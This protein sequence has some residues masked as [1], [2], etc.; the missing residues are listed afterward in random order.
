M[1]THEFSLSETVGLFYIETLLKANFPCE[2]CHENEIDILE[3]EAENHP[4]LI[5][6]FPLLQD[7]SSAS[8]PLKV[9]E[10]ICFFGQ[11][12]E[13]FVF[14]HRPKSNHVACILKRQG[15]LIYVDN[16]LAVPV[17]KNRADLASVICYAE[18]KSLL[19]YKKKK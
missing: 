11:T 10:E 13:K 7:D 12:Y 3:Y 5:A 8:F 15:Q 16:S 6:F 1:M 18:P 2:E 17:D 14:C 4:E 19:I 9:D